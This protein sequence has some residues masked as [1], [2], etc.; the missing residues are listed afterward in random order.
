MANKPAAAPAKA[1]APAADD[2]RAR[3]LNSFAAGQTIFEQGRPGAEMWI[4]QDGQVEILRRVGHLER[5]LALLETGDFFGEMSVLEDLPRSATARAV[6]AAKL[7]PIDASTFDQMLREHPEIAVRMMRKLSR[8]LR[9]YDESD[10]RAQEI[11]A[12]PLHGAS[13]TSTVPEP[14]SIDEPAPKP[15]PPAAERPTAP[16]RALARVVHANGTSFAVANPGESKI[17]RFD[18]VTGIAPEIDLGTL[19]TQRSLS[20]RH[21]RIVARDDSYFLR[22]EIGTA[23]GTFAGGVRLETGKEREIRDGENLRF[24][25]VELVFKTG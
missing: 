17:G 13:H 18:P 24:G 6:T 11:A 5:R 20:R 19:D 1:P 23:N 15:P 9:Q 12:G 21:A 3:F 16:V 8:R 14:V 2:P 10:A 7:L 22:E 4:I 25:Q